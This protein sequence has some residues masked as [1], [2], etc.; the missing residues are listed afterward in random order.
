MT[1][2]RL[3][4]RILA[5]TALSLIALTACQPPAPAETVPA[6]PALTPAAGSPGGNAAGAGTALAQLE[7][8]TVKGRAPK[9]GYSREMFGAAWPDM[10]GDGC[11]ERNEILA[12]DLTAITYKSGRC[13]VA[14]GT[15][16]DPYTGE[17]IGFVRGTATSAAVQIDHIVALSD[18]WQKGAQ[19]L[20]GGDRMALA[21]DPL[22]L[23]AADGPANGAKGDGDAATWLPPNKGFRCEYVAL[24]T[25][26]KAK[27]GLWMTRAESD[28]IRNVL[29][30]SCPDQPV[31]AGG[32]A[33]TAVA[34][35][36]VGKPAPAP[37]APGAVSYPNCTAVRSA[38]AAPIRAGDP[39]FEAK[40]DRDGDGIGCE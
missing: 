13:V 4:T 35:A 24:Q 14:T 36:P 6:R 18:A 23:M 32:G 29:I 11:D 40:F 7:T 12:R 16:A 37:A 1:T 28:A 9:T 22:N 17:T 33:V 27:Y 21:N 8:I 38:G 34:A 5:G 26:V 30:S 3:R 2:L 25:A 10:D 31:P 20:S 19:Q 39:G 15:L